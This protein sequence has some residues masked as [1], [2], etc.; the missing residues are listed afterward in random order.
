VIRPA[1]SN[2]SSS[3]FH[4]TARPAGR[5][6]AGIRDVFEHPAK[7]FAL[8]G[9]VAA[10]SGFLLMALRPNPRQMWAQRWPTIAFVGLY[11]MALH[12]CVSIRGLEHLPMTGPVILAGNHIN[13]TAMDG[14]LIGARLLMERG[15]LP[16]FVSIADP[17]DPVLRHF[18]RLMG[19][20]EGVILPIHEG[21]TTSAMIEYLRNPEAFKR[22][23]PI[24][25][26]FPAG[27][28]DRDLHE[29]LSREW[30]TSAAVAAFETGAPIVPF[31]VE[32][33][34]YHWGP[35]DILKAGAR[36]LAA[37]KAF[38]FRIHL[39]APVYARHPSQ[40]PDHRGTI[41]LVRQSVVELACEAA[42]NAAP[43][44]EMELC[45][46]PQ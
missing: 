44:P 30:R 4:E 18:V 9:L 45:G 27:R 7:T 17:P 22:E 41:D 37:G 21:A 23:Q 42:R 15:G 13:K 31:F 40:N 29:Q 1:F 32:G 43:A 24:L 36:T 35:L 28:A 19:R 34:P 10:P 6:L 5:R 26:I 3:E 38:D 14:M 11:Q 12:R 16:K 25:G 46:E 2:P 8:A 20:K 39:G 33:L